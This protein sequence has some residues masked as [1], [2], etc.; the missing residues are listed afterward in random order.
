[1]GKGKQ[2]TK[3]KIIHAVIFIAVIAVLAALMLLDIYRCPFKAVTGIP[4][5]GCGMTR[6]VMSALRGDFREAFR[7]HPLWI[8]AVPLVLVEILNAM[9]GIKI[10]AKINNIILMI[11][12]ILLLAVYII[13]LA[14]NTLVY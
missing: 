14:T 2:S 8:V 13:R 3:S 4:C 1:M 7:Y 9:G 12:G 5:P 10:P 11:A 6:A